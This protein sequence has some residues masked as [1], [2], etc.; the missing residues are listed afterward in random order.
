VSINGTF[1]FPPSMVSK[2][3]L[4]VFPFELSSGVF[5]EKSVG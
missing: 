1:A 5:E 3:S 2:F 4:L